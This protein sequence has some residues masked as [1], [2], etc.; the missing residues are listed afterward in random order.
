MHAD[1][2][3]AEAS[4]G[5]SVGHYVTRLEDNLTYQVTYQV[6]LT[7]HFFHEAVHRSLPD[8]CSL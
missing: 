5:L 7:F 4:R 8:S 6:R 3:V 2:C 1:L